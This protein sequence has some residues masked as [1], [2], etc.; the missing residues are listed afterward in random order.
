MEFG[1]EATRLEKG[2]IPKI[3][4]MSF[5]SLCNVRPEKGAKGAGAY[6]ARERERGKGDILNFAFRTQGAQLA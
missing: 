3:D 6:S 4:K 5:S 1:G 2:D